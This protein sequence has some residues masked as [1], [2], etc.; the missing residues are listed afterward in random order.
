MLAKLCEKYVALIQQSFLL[1]YKWM[2]P[3]MFTDSQKSVYM[4]SSNS[5]LTAHVNEP[6]FICTCGGTSLIP[7]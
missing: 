3:K 7:L 5:L 2:F 4:L 1:L 6:I